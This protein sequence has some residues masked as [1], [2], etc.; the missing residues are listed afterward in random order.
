MASNVLLVLVGAPGS[1]KSHYADS[2]E[3]WRII[4][5]EKIREAVAGDRDD[6]S[7][8]DEVWELALEGIEASLRAGEKVV[9]DATNTTKEDRA[10][11]IDLAEENGAQ[12]VCA[13]FWADEATC[14][15]NL[16]H[17]A[18]R[19]DGAVAIDEDDVRQMV[20]NLERWP[21]RQ[22]EG[23]TEVIEMG[24]RPPRT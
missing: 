4:A 15:V 17:R 18:R 24:R 21:P 20:R 2:L 5:A 3:G 14:L 11:L 16:R 12:A 23:F 7:R 9:F 8:E 6:M 1:G 19:D 22:D 13:V 10:S